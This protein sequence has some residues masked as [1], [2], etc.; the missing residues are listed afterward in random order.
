MSKT[1]FLPGL[2][3]LVVVFVHFTSDDGRLGAKLREFRNFAAPKCL[4]SGG[5][6]SRGRRVHGSIEHSVNWGNEDAGFCA[7]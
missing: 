2:F 3:S 6:G 5:T 1:L 4:H 7:L